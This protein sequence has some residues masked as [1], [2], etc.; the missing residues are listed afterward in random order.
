MLG[1]M[2]LDSLRIIAGSSDKDAAVEVGIPGR[3]TSG[4]TINVLPC[5]MYRHDCAAKSFTECVTHFPEKADVF[6]RV[7]IEAPQ[8][9]A[10]SVDGQKLQ[11]IVTHPSVDSMTPVIKIPWEAEHR[12]QRSSK[13]SQWC[14]ASISSNFPSSPATAANISKIFNC[15]VENQAGCG[16]C[17][18][19]FCPCCYAE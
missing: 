5:M 10:S 2:N 7:F 11:F 9:F 8:G 3:G 16:N 13:P 12:D 14:V 1:N 6:A 18:K 15:A 17:S 4:A 19:G